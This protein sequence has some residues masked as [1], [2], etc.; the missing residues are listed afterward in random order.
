MMDKFNISKPINISPFNG[1]SSN[2]KK[3]VSTLT[4]ALTNSNQPTIKK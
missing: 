3:V 1:S 4:V 2:T